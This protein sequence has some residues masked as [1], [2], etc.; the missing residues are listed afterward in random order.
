VDP[1]EANSIE[2]RLAELELENA[3]L[4][5]INQALIHRVERG[6]AADNGNSFTVFQVSAELEHRIQERTQALEKA[7]NDLKE[8]NIALEE[9]RQA[10]EQANNRLAIAVDT[11][12]DGFAQWDADDSLV[13]YN[14]RFVEL[15]PALRGQLRIGM[16]FDDYLEILAASGTVL[17]ANAMPRHWRSERYRYHR[18]AHGSQL[19]AMND[20]RWLRICERQTDDGGRVAVYTDITEIKRQERLLREQDLAAHW[21]LLEATVNSLRQ[22]IAVFDHDARLL[23]WNHRF[24]E[25]AGLDPATPAVGKPLPEGSQVPLFCPVDGAYELETAVGRVLEIESSPMPNAGFVITCSD[26][27]ERKRDEQALRESE[28]K[29]RLVTDAMPAL[30]SYVDKDQVYRFTNK[31]YEDWFGLP[32]SQINGRTLREVLGAELYD[33]RRH[34]VERALAGQ[35]SVFELK[36]PAPKRSVE[37]AQA[38]FIPHIGEDGSVH[39]FY[40]LIQDI[41][42]A[43]KAEQVLEHAKEQLEARV[44]ERT[45]E[46]M[47]SNARLQEAIIAA[48]EANQSKTRFFAAASHDLLQPLN[49]AR[50]F[51]TSL[52]ER[53]PDGDLGRLVGNAASSFE[54][55]DELINTLLELSRIDAGA[56]NV[57]PTHFFIDQLLGQLATEFAPIAATRGL[58]LRTHSVNAVV[59]S[60]WVLLGRILRNFLSNALRYTEHGGVMLGVRRSAEGVL[61]GV[62]DQGRGIPADKLSSVFQEFQRLPEHSAMCHKGMGL[63]LAIVKRLSLRLNHRLVVRS[64]FGRGSFFGVLVPYGKAEAASLVLR[65]AASPPAGNLAEPKGM[66]ILLIDNEPAILDGMVTLLSGWN[67][68]PLPALGMDQALAQLERLAAPPDAILADYHLDDGVTGPQVIRALTARLGHPLPAALITA[69]RTDEVKAEAD[70]GGWELLTKPVRPARLRALIGHFAKLAGAAE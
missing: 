20:G 34:F 57:E 43:R 3:K 65:E 21:K 16:S 50:L 42:P 48:E 66:T 61:I 46:L 24:C 55:V 5:K 9:A 69:D 33:P 14:L 7:M 44:V 41:T 13:R 53:V 68:R 67:C 11:I 10:A 47:R 59:H 17:E 39:G 12:A 38:T 35:A 2:A 19:Q 1:V 8:S 22:G 58:G 54:A 63:G 31:G 40:A 25:L 32:I 15:Q 62:W 6:M 36:M 49:A 28:R 45:T 70:A 23:A 37:Y 18:K 60:D 29:L 4:R 27:T 52:S 56:V 51:L 30:I 64:E 26:V